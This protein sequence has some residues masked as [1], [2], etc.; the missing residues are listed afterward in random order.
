MTT[1][2]P[3]DRVRGAAAWTAVAATVPYLTLKLLWLTGHQVGVD[4]PAEMDKLWLV[5][6]LT[7]GMDAIAV[8]LALSFVRPWGRRAPAGLL[9]FPMWVATGLLGT[10]LVA[11]P[12]SALATLLFGAE[13]APGG[14]SGNQ[15]PGGLDDWVFVVV[16][17]GFSVQGLALITAF[18]LY[19]GRR[20][21][22]LLR[23]RIGD[24]PDS[25]TLTLQ[26]ALSGVA[27]VLALG[28]AAARGYWAAGGATGLPVL[29][30]EERSRSAAVLDGVIAVMA[31]AAVTA[32]LALVFR[33][34][35]ERR[36][37]V[38]LVVAWTAA[39]SLFGWGSWQLVVFGTVT[40]VTDPR[41]AVPGLMP[42]V[43]TAQLLTGLLVLV[44][45]AIALVERA[46]AHATT[47]GTA[48]DGTT[49][50]GTAAAARAGTR[51]AQT[52]AARTPTPRS[53]VAR[54]TAAVESA[55]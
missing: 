28:V 26:R 16:Y 2:T 51:G 6:L 20:W 1:K 3:A 49:I 33:A 30:A 9:A 32:L 41:K 22:G 48:T 27:A 13:K 39:G 18:L 40:D 25:P 12:L 52:P 50:D 47:D 14:G 7:F 23:S 31:V 36:L 53:T 55:G 8:L 29:F 34:R 21:A 19:A 17:G 15:G 46:A 35:P 24:L 5:N 43:E 11:L 37:R 4:D 45:G 38:P 42:L 54:T 10:I 44:V